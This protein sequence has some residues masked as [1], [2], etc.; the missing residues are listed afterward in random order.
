[1]WVSGGWGELVHAQRSTLVCLLFS[2]V[3]HWLWVEH[4]WCHQQQ[5]PTD[6]QDVLSQ[7]N[8]DEEVYMG[9]GSEE[10]VQ[11]R[12]HSWFAQVRC[13][14]MCVLMCVHGREMCVSSHHT[15]Q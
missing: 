9:N 3:P 13:V 7:Y 15:T 5:I 4:G 2:H 14:F 10:R 6:L 12:L 8:A 11:Q 1:M